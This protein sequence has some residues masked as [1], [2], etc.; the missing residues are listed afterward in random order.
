MYRKAVFSIEG[1]PK[2]VIGYTEG[3]RW[4]GW[5]KPYF[6]I[7]EAFTIM[8]MNN[9]E[10]DNIIIYRRATDTFEFV[11]E[12]PI[13]AKGRNIMTTDGIKHVYGIG[14]GYWTWSKDEAEPFA[15]RISY[16]LDVPEETILNLL[17]D[18]RKLRDVATIIHDEYLPI[19]EEIA[20]LTE[21]LKW[22]Y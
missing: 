1:L 11:S 2:A 16:L 21:V 13:I 19:D 6:E 5:Y 17:T 22:K 14:A 9:M 18:I 4:N 15:E 20:Q 12:E 10:S 3:A 7:D 8:M